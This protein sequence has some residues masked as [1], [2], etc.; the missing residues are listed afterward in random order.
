M[1]K[2]IWMPDTDELS[3]GT[4]NLLSGSPRLQV[5]DLIAVE[6]IVTHFQS[7]LIASI[8]AREMIS[9]AGFAI[10]IDETS[11][12]AL[13]IGKALAS[14]SDT[15]GGDASGRR[16]RAAFSKLHCRT[17][18]FLPR[19]VTKREHRAC[20]GE[21]PA[22]APQAARDR[23]ASAGARV[24]RLFQLGTALLKWSKTDRRNGFWR[25]SSQPLPP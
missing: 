21:T 8:E 17:R 2:T 15:D 12:I 23:F 18:C 9:A 3:V 22:R 13:W 10:P 16:L 4:S 19:L 7:I 6:Q 20:A 25:T 24:V 11:S 1:L 14:L 5:K